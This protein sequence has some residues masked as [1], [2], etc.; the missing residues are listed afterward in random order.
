MECEL[1]TVGHGFEWSS[2]PRAR[3]EDRSSSEAIHLPSQDQGRGSDVG[4]LRR[5]FRKGW[6][7]VSFHVSN[8]ASE[9]E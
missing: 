4:P 6:L 9:A 7:P 1:D 2:D 8:F 5:L 3:S